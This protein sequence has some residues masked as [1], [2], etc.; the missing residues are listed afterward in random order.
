[1][2]KSASHCTTH[3][4]CRGRACAGSGWRRQANI[5]GAIQGAPKVA[6][7]ERSGRPLPARPAPERNKARL[8]AISRPPTEYVD[9]GGM[10][11]ERREMDIISPCAVGGDAGGVTEVSKARA[12]RRSARR[13]QRRLSARGSKRARGDGLFGRA[14]LRLGG[15]RPEGP[16][17]DGLVRERRQ[18]AR[19]GPFPEA[20]G[21]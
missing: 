19:W 18:G 21:A 5:P 1:M 13:G 4:A 17:R 9:G 8:C 2:V 6:F 10:S 16:R 7:W 14:R 11:D 3:N 20:G 15:R 12:L